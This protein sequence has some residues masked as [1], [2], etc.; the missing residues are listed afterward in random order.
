MGRKKE[1]ALDLIANTFSTN[2]K[3]VSQKLHNIR[4]QFHKELLKISEKKSGNG[5]AEGYK[6]RWPNCDSLNFLYE[7]SSCRR[8]KKEK[9][10]LLNSLLSNLLSLKEI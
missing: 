4:N 8:V 5:A 6:S 9:N 7:A 1:E 10:D 3:E 2:G